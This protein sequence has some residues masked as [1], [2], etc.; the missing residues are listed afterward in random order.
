MCRMV[1]IVSSE[2]TDF[3]LALREAPRS[4]A[5]LS[6]AHPHGWGMAVWAKDSAWTVRKSP[7]CAREDEGFGAMALESRGSMLVAHIRKKTVGPVCIENTHP[8]QRG[9]WVFAHNG[10]IEDLAFLER[11]TSKERHA[12]IEGDTDSEL[13]FSWLMS[14]LDEDGVSD[15]SSA[16][17]GE[18]LVHAVR[19]IGARQGFGGC[20]FLLARRDELYAYRQGRTLF[21]LSRGPHDEVR[22]ER[23]SVETGAIIETPWTERRGAVLVAS[24]SMTDEPWRPIGE[25]TLVFIERTDE[26]SIHVLTGPGRS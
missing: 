6:T 25:G 4:L 1:G 12:Q 5:T 11:G 20:N 24:E 16:E 14:R 8:F 26:P 18:V 2:S 15:G 17:V 7:L 22:T 21:L 13:F 23:A 3:R 10:T 19:A 9:G